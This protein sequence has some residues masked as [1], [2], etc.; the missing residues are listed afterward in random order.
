MNYNTKCYTHCICCLALAA[1]I[2]CRILSVSLFRFLLRYPLHIFCMVTAAIDSTLIFFCRLWFEASFIISSLSWSISSLDTPFT[3][4]SSF[5]LP[6][7]CCS[8]LDFIFGEDVALFGCFGELFILL[9]I[10]FGCVICLC[11]FSSCRLLLLEEVL[12]MVWME[13]LVGFGMV[14]CMSYIGSW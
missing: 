10:V 14:L 4:D 11:G 2:A 12:E 1:C 3:L 8:V 9:L 13:L 6:F 7:L 5:R